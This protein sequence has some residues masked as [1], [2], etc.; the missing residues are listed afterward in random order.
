MILC[1]KKLTCSQLRLVYHT[2]QTEQKLSY[3]K[4]IAHQRAHNTSR[5]SIGLNAH[6]LDQGSLK[7]TENST[8]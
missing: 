8:I 2:E 3:R 5:A 1:S 6:D 4:Q 7:V